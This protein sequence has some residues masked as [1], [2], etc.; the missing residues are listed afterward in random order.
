MST[1][2]T[3]VLVPR[4]AA[5]RDVPAW[6]LFTVWN[7]VAIGIALF[8]VENPEN[9]PFV[10]QSAIDSARGLVILV[11]YALALA[12]AIALV[13]GAVVLAQLRGWIPLLTVREGRRNGPILRVHHRY[14]LTRGFK[15]PSGSVLALNCRPS[16]FPTSQGKRLDIR[17]ASVWTVS[18]SGQ[19]GSFEM[20]WHIDDLMAQQLNDVLGARGVEV[21]HA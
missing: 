12:S 5:R 10:P 7:M 11:L 18:V 2:L 9:L 19:S 13:R 3:R 6:T 21:I 4:S 8:F 17:H 15:V 1:S 14:G 20:P 16:A